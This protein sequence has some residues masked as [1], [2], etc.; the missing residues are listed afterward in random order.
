M[1]IDVRGERVNDALAIVMHYIDDAIM[2]G[3]PSV[4][5]LH[6]QGTGALREE[7]QKYLKTVPGISSVKDEDIRFGGFRVTIVTFDLF[8]PQKKFFRDL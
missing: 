8:L 1:E 4:R 5:I 3:V 2:L 6:G 7:I